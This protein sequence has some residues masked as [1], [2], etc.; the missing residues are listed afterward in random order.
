MKQ[1]IQS[2]ITLVHIVSGRKNKQQEDADKLLLLLLSLK[3]CGDKL[4]MS[5][6][7]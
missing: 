4:F 7:N 3:V 5:M 1:Y 6:I 2:M